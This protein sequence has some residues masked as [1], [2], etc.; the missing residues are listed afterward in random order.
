MGEQSFVLLSSG[1]RLWREIVDRFEL[2]WTA[3]SGNPPGLADPLVVRTLQMLPFSE[4][5]GV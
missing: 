3:A 2:D 4:G 1:Q 5:L